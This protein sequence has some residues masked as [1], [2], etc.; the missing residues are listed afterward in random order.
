MYYLLVLV[1]T[2]SC[3]QF[4]FFSQKLESQQFCVPFVV[5]VVVKE[6]NVN[7]NHLVFILGSLK[8][9]V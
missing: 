6:L 7:H 2:H 8:I 3:I 5:V 1:H 9:D 4:I